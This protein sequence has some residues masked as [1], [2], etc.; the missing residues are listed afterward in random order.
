MITAFQAALG[1]YI[2]EHGDLMCE[3]CFR[4]EDTYARPM[5][6]FELDEWQTQDAERLSWDYAERVSETEDGTKVALLDGVWHV[7]GCG[8]EPALYDMN[9]HELR[10]AYNDSECNEEGI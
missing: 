9:G 2:T 8:C 3:D 6:N 4:S 10:E 1:G 5:S 7:E